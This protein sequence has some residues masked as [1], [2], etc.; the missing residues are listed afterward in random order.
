LQYK[1]KRSIIDLTK[2]KV[3]FTKSKVEVT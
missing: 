2:S 3:Y 1:N